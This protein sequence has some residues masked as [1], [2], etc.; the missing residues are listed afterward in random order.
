MEP[1]ALKMKV[2]TQHYSLEV[3]S[4]NLS[5]G[6]ITDAG[7]RKQKGAVEEVF[8]DKSFSR[9]LER[10]LL[11]CQL[12]DAQFLINALA[13]H[14]FMTKLRSGWLLYLI[15]KAF[16]P[17]KTLFGITTGLIAYSADRLTANDF[18]RVRMRPAE[19]VDFAMLEAERLGKKHGKAV[20]V[21]Y[22]GHPAYARK[23]LP[24][25]SPAEQQPSG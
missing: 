15:Y 12:G 4:S 8:G 23:Y 7:D 19:F 2:L 9:P 14:G 16:G 17:K 22:H 13:S 6:S 11:E 5:Q 21:I 20:E 18:T 10:I 3:V 1:D 24:A 25:D